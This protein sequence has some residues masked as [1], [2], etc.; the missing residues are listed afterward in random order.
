MMNWEGNSDADHELGTSHYG[1]IVNGED[2]KR[3]V[4]ALK[5]IEI[6]SLIKYLC[7][8]DFN[9]RQARLLALAGKIE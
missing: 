1:R 5:R 7:Y 3:R 9:F 4:K 8:D 2:S 6:L